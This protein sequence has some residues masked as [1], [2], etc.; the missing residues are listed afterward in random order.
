MNSLPI[1]ILVCVP[2][3]Q[4]KILQATPP[5][6]EEENEHATRQT[7]KKTDE[8]NNSVRATAAAQQRWW[9][10]SKPQRHRC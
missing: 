4:T 10:Q 9:R 7:K 3:R 5:N 8:L 2:M 1:M 6:I